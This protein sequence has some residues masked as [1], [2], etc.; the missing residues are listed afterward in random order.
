LGC[1]K[2]IGWLTTGDVARIHRDG[3]I[4]IVDRSKD[5]IKSGDEWI[6]SIV[7]ES[8]AMGHPLLAPA[9]ARAD[10]DVAAFTHIFRDMGRK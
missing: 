8:A 10:T 6:S 7:V 1:R 5:I 3:T 9:A 2:A 4:E